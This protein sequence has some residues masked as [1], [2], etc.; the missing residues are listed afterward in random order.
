MQSGLRTCPK[1]EDLWMEYLRMELTYLNKL[2]ERK[3]ACETGVG[4]LPKDDKE[5]EQQKEENMDTFVSLSNDILFQRGSLTIQT[6][7]HGAV[8]ALPSS[9][10]LRK[11]FLEILDDVDLVQSEELKE[12]IMEDLKKKFSQN[13]DYWDWLARLQVVYTEGRKD[14]SK[15]FLLGK[16]NKA[17]EVS[18]D[19]D[20]LYLPMLCHN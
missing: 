15:E 18:V 7:Y 5:T 3:L 19:M 8:E 16:L 2:K 6:I 14:L 12:E 4:S 9:M 10:S 13:E 20:L 11:R 1:S 17:S